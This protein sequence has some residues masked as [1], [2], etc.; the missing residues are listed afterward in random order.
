MSHAFTCTRHHLSG[1]ACRS[2]L[3]KSMLR[4]RQEFCQEYKKCFLFFS[5]WDILVCLRHYLFVFCVINRT[6]VGLS[7][8]IRTKYSWPDIIIIQY[9]AHIL[10]NKATAH[11]GRGADSNSNT[12]EI[13]DIL[14]PWDLLSY[15]LWESEF[16]MSKLG[17]FICVPGGLQHAAEMA[18]LI[19]YREQYAPFQREG[20]P[21]PR[22]F[23]ELI[24]STWAFM[25]NTCLR[26]H[27]HKQAHKN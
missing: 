9:K 10:T 26:T 5:S 4:K 6:T 23:W 22:N 3:E 13:S 8:S 12:P 19:D 7:S 21:P 2:S 11:R 24:C 14:I 16:M 20:E 17:S 18:W 27:T 15:L 1:G 25:R